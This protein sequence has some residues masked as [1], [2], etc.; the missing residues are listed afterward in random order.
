M[1]EVFIALGANLGDRAANLERARTLLGRGVLRPAAVSS[2]YDTEPW[3]PIPQ[4]H[5]LNQ[6]VRGETAF[7]PRELLAKLLAIEETLGR[8]RAREQRYAAR[9]I[10]LDILLYDDIE[11]VEPGLEIPHPRLLERAFVLVPLH[12]IAPNLVVRGIAI[13]DALARLDAMGVV[14]LAG[15]DATR[16][17]S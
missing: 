11:L 1:A 5:Y 16:S 12:E 4:G 8:D 7:G 6:V 3:G 10:D 13:R 2:L 9:T 14:R 15:P 17:R